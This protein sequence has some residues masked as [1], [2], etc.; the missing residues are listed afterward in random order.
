MTEDQA[1]GMFIG[2]AVGDALGTFLEFGPCREPD[3]YLRNYTAGGPFDLPAGNQV[4]ARLLVAS[5]LAL[6]KA[7]C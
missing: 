5:E 1:Q 2:L 6:I 4:P 3:N 7:L